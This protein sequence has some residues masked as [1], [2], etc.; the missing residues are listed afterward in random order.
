MKISDKKNDK[1]EIEKTRIK[2]SSDLVEFNAWAVRV[3]KAGIIS[4]SDEREMES[5]TIKMDLNM[6]VFKKMGEIYLLKHGEPPPIPN[7][8]S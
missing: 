7:F 3:V 8:N 4:D 1:A 2:L 6:K 5:R